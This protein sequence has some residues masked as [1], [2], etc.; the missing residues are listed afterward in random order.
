MKVIFDSI[1]NRILTNNILRDILKIFWYSPNDAFLRAP[2]VAVWQM[3]K[4]EVR[5]PVLNIGCGDGEMDKKLFDGYKKHTAID[6]N[7]LSVKRARKTG[8]YKK[9]ILASAE[10][11][12][13]K[14]KSFNTV[15]SNSTFE[16][17]K[18]DRKAVEEV[19]RILKPGGEFIFNT[20]SKKL[21]DA[22]TFL[23]K[24]KSVVDKINERTN[25]FHHRSIDEWN[26]ILESNDL[27]L[28]EYFYY[29]PITNIKLWL[30]L[31][32]IS[33]FKPYKRELWSYMKDSPYG[34]L[35]PSK[36]IGEAWYWIL[37]RNYKNTFERE[38]TWLFI[39]T[40][41]K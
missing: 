5:S 35:L 24:D 3:L 41:K 26:N 21:L 28:D 18:N 23:I 6:S 4:L 30:N 36:F 29:H 19:S 34:R 12:P 32:N 10:R 7:N 27:H 14:D 37:Y 39:R 20:T 9:V 15:I 31:F 11:M 2:E 22:L 16:H 8:F 25:H 17:I 40:V 1:D 13:F 33:T 38:G